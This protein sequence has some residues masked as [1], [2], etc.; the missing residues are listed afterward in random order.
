MGPRK[1]I[2]RGAAAFLLAATLSA[3]ADLAAS[4]GGPLDQIA[5]DIHVEVQ[6]AWMAAEA[7]LHDPPAPSVTLTVV[8][9]ESEQ[10]LTGACEDL[11][12]EP[13][14]HDDL[15]D[16]CADAIAAV[17]DIRSAIQDGD[18]AALQAAQQEAESIAAAIEDRS[19]LL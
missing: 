14:D 11:A 15:T 19:A 6:T 1:R 17:R 2:V 12:A 10:S 3:C 8:L 7:G 4:T 18:R 5:A 16:E 9:D 13:G